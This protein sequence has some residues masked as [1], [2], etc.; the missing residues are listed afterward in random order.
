MRPRVAGRLEWSGADD[1]EDGGAYGVALGPRN[2]E[3]FPVYH[4][5]DVS[6]RRTSVKSWGTLTPYISLLNV[7]NRQNPLFFFYEYDALPPARTGVSMFPFLPT[8]G[9]DVSF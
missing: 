6:L 9:L 7:Y 3:R 5:L 8:I 4:R 2:G 1:E